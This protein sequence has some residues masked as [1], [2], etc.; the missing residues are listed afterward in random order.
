MMI[1]K[2]FNFLSSKE[3]CSK[4]LIPAV[5]SDRIKLQFLGGISMN[6]NKGFTLIELLVV[7]VIIGI[8]IAIALP[9]FIKV[10]EKAM[11]SQVKS[12]LRVIQVALERYATEHD[13]KYPYWL[14][15]GDATD[16]NASP[17][18]PYFN[19]YCQSAQ[20]CGDG[21]ALLTFGY[22]SIYPKNPFAAGG[23]GHNFSIPGMTW[24]YS[25]G[26][27][28]SYFEWDDAAWGSGDCASSPTGSATGNAGSLGGRRVG[29]PS[30]DAMWEVTEGGYGCI[31]PSIAGG[32]GR[33]RGWNGHP[34]P[35]PLPAND[36]SINCGIQLCQ[37]AKMYHRPFMAGNFYYYPIFGG[38][39][40]YGQWWMGEAPLGYHV[41][42]YGA[43]GNKGHDV[44]D[45]YGDFRENTYF[46]EGD[47]PYA[48]DTDGDMRLDCKDR[49]ASHLNNGPDGQ[50]DGVIT[51]ISSGVDA[52]VPM[53][54]ADLQGMHE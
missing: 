8:L 39:K 36:G 41:S 37:T 48:G 19:Q 23:G 51:V 18:S 7:I 43:P 40:M 15:G 32:P 52:R 12:N 27:T 24:A 50:F 38:E 33:S 9:N 34:P 17:L 31:A 25:D 26:S 29:G 35:P 16:P 5:S 21:D 4:C 13:G 6:R 2:F 1:S 46:C 28:S 42:V 10:K 54:N 47:S 14:M 45:G 44:Y 53:D 3:D 49:N 11:E 22:L 20:R 30:G